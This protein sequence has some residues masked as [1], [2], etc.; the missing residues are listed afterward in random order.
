MFQT[1]LGFYKWTA[2]K[3]SA[4]V[5]QYPLDLV[6]EFDVVR[7]NLTC[8]FLV[9]SDP[10]LNMIVFDLFLVPAR[11]Q[12]LSFYDLNTKTVSADELY[13]VDFL[14]SLNCFTIQRVK[15]VLMVQVIYQTP[16]AFNKPSISCLFR[17]LSNANQFLLLWKIN[18]RQLLQNT[19]KL[20]V[21]SSITPFKL[22]LQPIKTTIYILRLIFHD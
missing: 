11:V 8:S 17:Y 12:F 19:I 9:V 3:T 16:W 13:H 6:K 18:K 5:L 7:T 14:R 10:Y 4:H 21:I 22:N 2:V 20:H 15:W 1:V